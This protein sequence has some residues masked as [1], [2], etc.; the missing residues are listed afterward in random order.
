M[1]INTSI[2]HFFCTVAFV[3]SSFDNALADG[4]TNQGF[5]LN[6]GQWP[7]HVMAKASFDFG[8]VIL[9]DDGILFF[10]RDKNDM[11]KHH[12]RFNETKDT[13]RIL[14]AHVYKM[15][16]K[17]GTMHQP[18]GFDAGTFH[19]NFMNANHERNTALSCYKKLIVEN[20]YKGIDL[21]L[22]VT[23]NGIKYDLILKDRADP[24]VVQIAYEGIDNMHIDKEGNLH[25]KTSLGDI[26]EKMPIA[27]VERN[28]R[29][30]EPVLCTYIL[31]NNVVRFNI[32]NISRAR[33]EKLVIDPQLIFATYSGSNAD[34]WGNT[35]TYD[36]L[37]NLYAAGVAFSFGF[38][39]TTGAYQL[40]FNGTGGVDTDVAIMKFNATGQLLYATYLGG[41]LTE[42][43][44][45]I[46]VNKANELYILGT[47]GSSGSSGIPFPTTPG[48]Y[49]RTF[50]G[51]TNIYP[52]GAF[53]L[54]HYSQGSDLFISKLSADGSTLLASTLIG[55]SSNDGLIPYTDVLSRNYGDEFRSEILLDNLGFVY[56][57][58]HTQSN[59]IIN[60]TKPGFDLTF[61]GGGRDGVI[62]KLQSD[63]TDIVWN[64]YWGGS[65]FDACYSLQFGSNA[66]VYVTGA[67]TSPNLATSPSS[68]KP[69]YSG[70]IDGFIVS[71]SN[72][73]T[74][75]LAATYIGTA[76]VD[77]SYLI[78]TDA[79]GFVYIL[80][81]SQGNYP[82]FNAP[83]SNPNS[84]QFIHK[85]NST[86]DATVFSTVIGSGLAKI[87]FV[88]T[89]FLVNDCENI[90]IAGW[91]G[92]VNLYGGPFYQGGDTKNLPLTSNAFQSL[93]DGD[94]FYLMVLKKDLQKL[95][96]ATYFG[97]FGEIEHVDG[98]T[99]RFDKR[100]IV[101]QSVCAGC[102]GTS[103]FPVTPGA[104]SS[105]NNSSNCN[106][107]VFKFDL[108]SL[109][110]DFTLDT[111]ELCGS[112]PVT[113]TNKSIG[114]SVFIWDLGD[115]NISTSA[116]SF[117]HTYAQTGTY[118]IRLIAFDEATCIGKDTAEKTIEVYTFPEL[119]VSNHALTICKGDTVMIGGTYD[120][121]Y[122]YLW[123]PNEYISDVN[124]YNPEVF[125]PV[126]KKYSVIIT[127]TI[128]KCKGYDTVLVTVLNPARGTRYENITGCQ[129]KPTINLYNP[130]SKGFNYLWNFGDGTWSEEGSVL[131]HSYESFGEY[132]VT[133][134]VFNSF[135]QITDTVNVIIPPINIPNLITPNGDELNDKYVIKGMTD[136]WKFD[137]YNR[138]GNLIY[139][140]EP[141]DQS[142]QGDG[143]SDGIYYYL[144][145][146]PAGN[147]CKGWVQILK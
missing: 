95:L 145:T 51:G 57:A 13:A 45:S 119:G 97:G 1:R 120:N 131:T 128:T 17:G 110:A 103:M 81:Q 102:G 63:L 4:T 23:N 139:T 35:A 6:A 39:V 113:F 132:L 130:S 42:V 34:N 22:Y 27:F 84:H 83:Y 99:S 5:L 41:G 80:G 48:A 129:G 123:S 49:D 105:T 74:T 68:I 144:I 108:S 26:I 18:K 79:D 94:D 85:L 122:T 73:G 9:Q 44:T 114:G 10:L 133:V 115:G 67:T 75:L 65:G 53:D 98:G 90:F 71:L 64:T 70:N 47:T 66:I 24:S 89:A 62:I 143:L 56:I 59:N 76:T 116:T 28:N 78:Q 69:S 11:H 101:Y 37:G 112:G 104:H 31:E 8:D 142:W 147:K 40:N 86:L 12:P 20:A 137:I 52:L 30:K 141:Y 124:I 72:D 134:S 14:H 146:D 61:N 21:M 16:F 92:I 50:N 93:T 15:K 55:G 118:R 25:L 96:Y 60:A 136:H 107:A 117:T 127:N 58:S 82:V 54:I 135:C 100:G 87:D 91:G 7:A 126:T 138:W 2:V 125:P 3:I 88:P 121:T 19:V 140:R 46:I 77:Q 32:K 43:P 111:S 33:K 109:K 36:D 29:S 38:P 106:N